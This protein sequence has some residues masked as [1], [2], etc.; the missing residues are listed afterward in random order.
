MMKWQ[1]NMPFEG[2][3]ENARTVIGVWMVQPHEA[4]DMILLAA[5]V[6]DTWCRALRKPSAMSRYPVSHF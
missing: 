4:C 3:R 5:L 2:E 1:S 6:V